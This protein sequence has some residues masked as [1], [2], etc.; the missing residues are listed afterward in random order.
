MKRKNLYII[1]YKAVELLK[2][3]IID[4]KIHYGKCATFTSSWLA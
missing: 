2:F 1:L 4:L 3:L